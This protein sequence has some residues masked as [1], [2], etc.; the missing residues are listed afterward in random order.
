MPGQQASRTAQPGGKPAESR[1]ADV[2]DLIIT[3]IV[4]LLLDLAVFAFLAS[5]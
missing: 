2:I 3:V 5:Q 1:A 4:A